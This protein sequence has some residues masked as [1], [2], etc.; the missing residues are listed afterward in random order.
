MT[1]RRDGEGP[2]NI[3]PKATP[4]MGGKHKRLATLG[5]STVIQWARVGTNAAIFLVISH[6]LSLEEIGTVAAM[7]APVLM[8]RTPLISTVP[9]YLIQEKREEQIVWSSLFWISI[10]IGIL[11]SA[12]L[13]VLVP[14]FAGAL[15]AP[16]AY[17]YGYALS[18]CPLLWSVATVFDGMLRKA[19][20]TRLLAVRTTTASIGAAIVSLIVLALGGGGWSLVAFLIAN[21]ALGTF[22]IVMAAKWR[23][24]FA[25]DMAYVRN[26]LLRMLPLTGRHMLAA[27]TIPLLQFGVSAQLGVRAGGAFQIGARLYTLVDSIAVMPL[28]YLVMPLMSRMEDNAR[29]AASLGKSIAASSLIAAPVFFGM[30]TAAPFLL[31]LLLGQENGTASALVVQIFSL[32]GPVA[33][34]QSLVTQTLSGRGQL[35]TVFL[36]TL[37]MY[38]IAVVPALVATF[39]WSVEA[40]VTVYVVASALGGITISL[41]ISQRLLGADWRALLGGWLRPFLASAVILIGLPV[42]YAVD[43]GPLVRL[44]VAALAG[45]VGFLVAVLLIARPQL[46]LAIDLANLRGRLPFLRAKSPAVGARDRDP[47]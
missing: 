43:A 20:N 35:R 45:G 2:G 42:A 7:Q 15:H 6:F 16:D 8:V 41:A 39:F 25:V 22:S 19:L 18:V 14:L 17:A 24:S 30:A 44:V 47:S 11:A 12:A 13:L 29:V 33:I 26:S 31:P 34:V 9:E 1:A 46:E 32:L 5:W 40:V 38:G 36:R 4:P 3:S 28:R 23:P 21:A 37:A 10:G 27:A